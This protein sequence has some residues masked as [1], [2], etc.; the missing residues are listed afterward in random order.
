MRVSGSFERRWEAIKAILQIQ[1][2][3]HWPAH[4][5]SQSSVVLKSAATFA[6][7]QTDRFALHFLSFSFFFLLLVAPLLFFLRHL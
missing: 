6:S 2:A 4:R 1:C 3:V 7:S 5:I